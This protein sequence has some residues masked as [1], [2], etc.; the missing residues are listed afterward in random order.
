MMPLGIL[1][2]GTLAAALCC[3]L[4]SGCSKKAPEKGAKATAEAGTLSSGQSM[5][6]SLTEDG[7]GSRHNDSALPPI[8]CPL[9]KAGVDPQHL[10]PFED[11]Q[12]YVAFL[13]RPD[14]A[15]WQRPDDV[16]R[17]LHLTGTEVIADVGAGSG[18]FTFRLAA[19]VPQGRVVA[20]DIEPEMIRHI[21]HKAMTEGIR[22]VEP[23]LAAADDPKV[24]AEADIVFVCDVLHHVSDRPAWLLRLHD[25]MKPGARLTLV[26]FKDGDLPEGPPAALKIPRDEMLRLVRASGFVLIGEEKDLLPYQTFLVFR[27]EA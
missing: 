9:R 2:R 19:A 13:E 22:N 4:T 1:R 15:A 26:E 24:P 7:A 23:V 11:I 20:T 8:E 3:I 17:A 21:H 5:T 25:E 18:Y 16:V 27:K 10:K 12:K 14:R 6:A